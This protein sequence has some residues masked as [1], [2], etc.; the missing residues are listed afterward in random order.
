VG[1]LSR[2]A[3]IGLGAYGARAA[4]H[5]VRAAPAA[6]TLD[7][8][9][10]RGSTVSL[11][12]G[13]ALGVSASVSSALGAPD[14]R[15]ALA[16]LTAGLTGTAVGLYDDVVG[17]RPEQKTAKGFKGHLGALRE[18][19]ITSGLVKIV[20]VGAAGLVASALLPARVRAGRPQGR[21]GRGV[22]IALGAGVIAGSAN[23]ANLLDLRPGR[24][25]KAGLLV[26]APLAL[27]RQGGLAAGPVGAAGALLPLD[28]DEQ[29]MLGDSGAN[30]L[31]ALLG[32]A[33]TARTGRFGRAVLFAGIAGLTLASEKVSFTRV[34][35]STRGLREFDAWGRKPA[36][37]RAVA[38]GTAPNGPAAGPRDGSHPAVTA[39]PAARG[40]AVRPPASRARNA[41]AAAA[42]AVPVPEPT[43]AS[44]APSAGEQPKAP[45]KAVAKKSAAKKRVGTKATAPRATPV[46]GQ[47]GAASTDT[48]PAGPAD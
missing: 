11:A 23:L 38:A 32:V 40:K 25:L 12:G 37:G 16:A 47:D 43:L 27:G 28:L 35:E 34:I 24:A 14:G 45:K 21:V 48:A 30:G 9:N 4:V 36:A 41:S 19:R 33:A 15:S 2:A 13:P 42:S 6:H 22:D 10:F 44:D 31:G 17:G 5:V 39:P 26:G 1:F 29:I 3:L 8:T 46:A 20:G 7:R 18:G